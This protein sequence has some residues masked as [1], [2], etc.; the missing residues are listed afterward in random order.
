MTAERSTSSPIPSAL[1]TAGLAALLVGERV[2]GAGDVRTLVTAS[3]GFLLVGAL[4]LRL[5]GFAGAVGDAREVE[6]R[7]LGSYGG[8]ALAL[9]LYAFSTDAGLGLL[10]IEGETLRRAEVALTVLWPAT[11]LVSVL[12]IV[13]VELV[14]ARMPIPASVE[15]RRV[16]TSLQAG[17]SLGL[18][19]VFLVS[20]NYVA[21]ERDVRKDVSY[22]RT[23][24]PSDGTRSLV[25]R[26]DQKLQVI[27]FF[28]KGSDVLTQVEPYFAAL[29]QV[30]AKRLSYQV[31]DV[32]LA[33][34]L[35]RKQRVREN[36]NVLLVTGEG[37]EAKGRAFEV[38]EELTR[39]RRELKKLDGSFQENFRRLVTPERKL[40]LTVGHGERNARTGDSRAGDGATG[41]KDVLR[42]LNLKT[43]DLGIAQGLGS[44]VA[45]ATTAVAVMGPTEKFMP[46]EAA[47]LL[48]Y[49]RGGGRLVLMLDPN[50]DVGLSPLL[51]ALG[52]ELLP[53]TV[54]SDK[55]FMRRTFT[56]SDRAIVYS[57]KYTSHPIV[58]T[59][60]KHQAEL[61]TVFVEG[62]AL[63]KKAPAGGD[64]KTQ[65]TFPLTS[66]PEFWRDL[67]GN[68]TREADEATARM[69]MVA[70]VTVPARKGAS[71]SGAKES[72]APEGRVVIIGDGDFVTDKLAGNPGNVLLFVDA[73]AWL[74]GEEK[75]SGEVTSE[76]D[77]AIE[78]SREQDKVWFYATTFA[79]PVPVLLLGVWVAQRRRRRGKAS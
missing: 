55:D 61:A 30:G 25:E 17:L 66:G 27:L 6:L 53:G 29:A 72:P 2:L 52:V 7:L 62:V 46:E 40:N 68:F 78:H 37:E 11:L 1:L 76:E 71:D 13:F 75:L 20:I 3:G 15:L 16:R 33:P 8:V 49:V 51:D 14:Y 41:L 47:A 60:S 42:R 48:A 4:V 38:G 69:N 21:S 10:G 34:E 19:A 58:T 12:A 44:E 31:M 18:C 77:V 50:V 22:F 59:V 54:V 5:R 56:Q 45:S 36:G 74:I 64:A 43:E 57:N 73:L 23:T 28:R 32:A 63:G 65:V 35:A 26:L 24:R 70:A 9:A 39:A 67:N 79:V